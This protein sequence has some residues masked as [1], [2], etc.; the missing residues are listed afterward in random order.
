[1]RSM[2]RYLVAAVTVLH[3]LIHLLGAAKGFG[4]AVVSQLREPIDGVVGAGWLL[5]A[6]L[7]IGA[8]MGLALR[9]RLW[10]AVAVVAA[11]VSQAVILTSWGDAKAG[12][13]P[14][15]LLLLA[16]GYGYV[17]TGPRSFRADFRRRAGRTLAVPVP[18]G[19]LSEA[20]LARLPGPLAG[21]I[22]LSGAV[23]Q[24][25]VANFH[26]AISGRIRG[27][28]DQRWM[29]FRGEQVNSFSAGQTAGPT[30]L[31]LIDATMF[32]LPVDVFH[33]FEAGTATMRVKI[34]SLVPM[35][36]AAGADMDRA[37]TVTLFN[38]LCVLA[39]AA[40]VDAP[41]DWQLVD[42]HRVRG[43]Y[44]NGA[45]TVTAELVFDDDHQLVD[46]V[47]DDRLRAAP[48]GRSF[49]RQRWSTPIR[50]YR[51]FGARRIGA[52]G[53][54][55]WHAPAPENEFCYLEFFV[56]RIV[57]NAGRP[58]RRGDP[59]PGA[60]GHAAKDQVAERQPQPD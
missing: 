18:G 3:G 46:F 5:A 32:G 12:T 27:G 35:V 50:G 26:A 10:W 11:I 21:Y 44:T 56:D 14:N 1:M 20:D 45:H 55:R 29:S 51:S 33:V 37:E 19:V 40:L 48:N 59:S 54:A 60:A 24:P 23:G 17:S 16:A 8:G 34:C 49:T 30:R 2:L 58:G 6:V 42:G 25:R 36:D 31:F 47:S 7:L 28:P 39:P 41:V 22:R 38:D 53:E 4:W 57:Y 13:A 9:V 15:V 43:S 52:A